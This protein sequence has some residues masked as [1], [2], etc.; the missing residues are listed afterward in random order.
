M[1]PKAHTQEDKTLT[2]E[3]WPIERPIPYDNNPRRCPQSAIDKV[4]ASLREFGFRQ[5]I[6]VDSEAVVVVGHTRLLAAK[7]LGMKQVPVHVAADLSPAQARAYRIA[8]NR[9]NEETAWE[10]DLLSVE[11]AELAVLDYEIDVL[12]FDGQELAE[13]L[14]QP[15]LGLTDPDEVPEPPVEPI[16]QAG[17]LWILGEHRLL[18]GDATVAADVARV[19][20][21]ARATLMAT[22]PPYLVGYDGGN[23]PQTWSKTG[24]RISSEEKTRHWDAYRDQ[25]S[26][27]AFYEQFLRT[28]LEVAL[29]ERPF[30]Y[31]WLGVMRLPVVV[32]AWEHVGLLPH[33]LL[34]WAKSRSVLTRCD[35]QWNYEG[36]MYGWRRGQRPLVG[37]RPPAGAAALWRI[38]SAIEDGAAGIHPTMKPVEVVRRPIEYHTKPGEVIFEPFCGSGTAIVA[39]EMTGRSCRALEISPAFCDVAVQRWERF[40]GRKAVR[41]GALH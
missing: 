3:L 28:A 2:V 21:G 16:T 41:D 29:S 26:S 8:D 40:T 36:C 14:A 18:C 23:H 22:D 32:T 34:I 1:T 39:A 31:E 35:Y 27:V 38:D 33:Q 24:R 19:M 37:R 5:A 7:R 11:I 6:V 12:G 9:T 10:S 20:N 15:T 4:A 13:L 25:E 30:V 17:D